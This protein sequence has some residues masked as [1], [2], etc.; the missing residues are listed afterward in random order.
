LDN[1][2]PDIGVLPFISHIGSVEIVPENVGVSPLKRPGP[3][4]ARLCRDWFPRACLICRR[5]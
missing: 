2:D 1:A 3:S 5:H 4:H